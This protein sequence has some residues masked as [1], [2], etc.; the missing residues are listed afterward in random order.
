MIFAMQ[1]FANQMLIDARSETS[2][3]TPAGP[4]LS[5]RL[6]STTS[7]KNLPSKHGLA[8]PFVVD[9]KRNWQR[10]SRRISI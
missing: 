7:L 5:R 9:R 2:P 4:R 6:L 3:E 8:L 1:S 10:K